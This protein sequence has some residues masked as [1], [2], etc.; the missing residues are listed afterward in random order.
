MNNKV[1][2]FGYLSNTGGQIYI[3]GEVVELPVPSKKRPFTYRVTQANG[4]VFVNTYEY[5]NGA[6]KHTFLAY[7]HYIFG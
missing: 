2:Q 3:N 6:W 1:V 4:K 5:K 7:W